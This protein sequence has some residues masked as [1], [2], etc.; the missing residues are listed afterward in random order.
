MSAEIK[1]QAAFYVQNI[2]SQC[3]TQKSSI[4][5]YPPPPVAFL[6]MH[7]NHWTF[8]TVLQTWCLPV[9]VICHES[10]NSSMGQWFNAYKSSI[11]DINFV[12]PI[13]VLPNDE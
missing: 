3:H 6:S 9:A 8:A 12:I 2:S 1:L 7:M 13:S 5:W 11:E 4:K 10:P